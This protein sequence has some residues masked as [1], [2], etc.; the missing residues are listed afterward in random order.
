MEKKLK[1]PKTA[2]TE[3]FAE[4]FPFITPKIIGKHLFTEQWLQSKTRSCIHGHSACKSLVKQERLVRANGPEAIYLRKGKDKRVGRQ[5]FFHN[6]AVFSVLMNLDLHGHVV[7]Y[8]GLDQ[9]NPNSDGIVWALD[10][11]FPMPIEVDTGNHGAKA[12]HDQI[13]KY[14]NSP[15]TKILY[16]TYPTRVYNHGDDENLDQQLFQEKNLRRKMK[17][18][19]IPHEL[20]CKILSTT[21]V[22]ASDPN[23]DP[24][25]AK[26]WRTLNGTYTT[27]L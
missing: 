10:G 21:Y 18:H 17:T 2:Y 9:K 6:Q 5:Y 8:G 7:K 14:D 26:I 23:V 3:R 1:Y 12:L 16:I 4:L 20:R 27:V 15:F 13:M 25:T 22:Q 11:I 19:K 24:L